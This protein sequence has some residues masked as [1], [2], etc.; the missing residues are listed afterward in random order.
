MIEFYKRAMSN[1]DGGELA[2]AF[3]MCLPYRFDFYCNQWCQDVLDLAYRMMQSGLIWIAYFDEYDT[4]EEAKNIFEQMAEQS[5]NIAEGGA[6]WSTYQYYF[7][8]AGQAFW[9][10]WKTSDDDALYWQKLNH[11]FDEHHVG[12]DKSCF[13]PVKF[14]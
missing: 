7:S 10:E 11:I 3:Y 9:D 1:M 4:A 13:V 14:E 6:V 12:F 8:G 5:P 2:D